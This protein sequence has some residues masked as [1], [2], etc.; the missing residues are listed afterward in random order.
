[1]SKN[2]VKLLTLETELKEIHSTFT[3]TA[4]VDGEIEM[5]FSDGHPM[6]ACEFLPE[7]RTRVLLER[8]EELLL[9]E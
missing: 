7:S 3:H 6:V 8:I 1:M 2:H 9:D 4:I 5:Y